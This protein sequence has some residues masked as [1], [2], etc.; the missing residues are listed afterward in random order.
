MRGKYRKRRHARIMRE[1]GTIALTE[2]P[3]F[4]QHVQNKLDAMVAEIEDQRSK[5]DR[6]VVEAAIAEAQRMKRS[7]KR[8][9]ANLDRNMESLGF[10][11][12]AG[13]EMVPEQ[14]E[15]VS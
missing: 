10:R 3:P 9:C 11:R 14:F 13:S 2:R 15:V 4:R 1:G 5:V 6:A 8:G 12:I 7:K